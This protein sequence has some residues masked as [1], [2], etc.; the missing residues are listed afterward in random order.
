[1]PS[2]N[3]FDVP[4]VMVSVQNDLAK[5]LGAGERWITIKPHGD[6]A[7]GVPVLIRENPDGTRRSTRSSMS[8][9][10]TSNAPA[11]SRL[12]SSCRL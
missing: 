9:T 10:Y 8:I 5:A 1:M 6:G 4:V 7:K 12:L 2:G 3:R 11:P